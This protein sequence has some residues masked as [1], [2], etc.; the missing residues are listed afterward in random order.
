MRQCLRPNLNDHAFCALDLLFR[1][2]NIRITLQRRQD[3]LIESKRGD[4]ACGRRF[5]AA[6]GPVGKDAVWRLDAGRPAF[7]FNVRCFGSIW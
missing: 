2:Q 6:K 4:T 3:R 1:P 7:G 5:T